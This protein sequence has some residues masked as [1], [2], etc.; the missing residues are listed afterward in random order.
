MVDVEAAV[1]AMPA[2]ERRNQ[3]VAGEGQRGGK[4]CRNTETMEPEE[5]AAV[6]PRGVSRAENI[7]KLVPSTLRAGL[8][9]AQGPRPISPQHVPDNSDDVAADEIA[10]ASSAARGSNLLKSETEH[11][12]TADVNT[13]RYRAFSIR[14]LEAC[15]RSPV[16][17]ACAIRRTEL[18]VT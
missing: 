15:T 16:F 6:S 17:A 4:R 13:F 18:L 12:E 2:T 11:S 3:A 1:D 9:S 5:S 10:A 14:M 8:V 7:L